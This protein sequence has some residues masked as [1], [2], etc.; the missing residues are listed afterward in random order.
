MRSLNNVLFFFVCYLFAIPLLLAEEGLVIKTFQGK[1]ISPHV[2]AITDL[3]LIIYKEKPYLYE[4]TEEEYRP[5]IEYYAD[6]ET[7]RACL[8]FDESKPVGVAI[9]MPLHA[10]R[11]K[12][13]EPFLSMRPEEN[14]DE[15]F[16]LGELLL[17][18]DYRGN[19]L[20]KQMYLECERLATQ[21]GFK[22]I[23][24][25]K[26]DEPESDQSLDG[27]WKK[28]GFEKCE[29]GTFVVYWK[30]VGESDES[31]HQMRYWIKSLSLEKKHGCH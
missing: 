12:Y 16:Y 14:P 29:E 4:G 25:C 22:K 24:F 28:L 27:F 2:K 6:S 9:G 31:P 10:M 18:K 30:N 15:L 1:D 3:C 11:D 23:C 19:N 17:L 13:R 5:F 20:G 8:L 7:N 26:I 21:E